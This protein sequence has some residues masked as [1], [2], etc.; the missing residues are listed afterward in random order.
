M[1]EFAQKRKLIY[2]KSD[3]KRTATQS[4]RR[5]IQDKICD[6]KCYQL[7]SLQKT[8]PAGQS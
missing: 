7:K 6:I 2:R 4:R 1:Y 5:L 8:G 3:Q